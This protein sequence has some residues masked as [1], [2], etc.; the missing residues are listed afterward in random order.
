MPSLRTALYELHKEL[1]ARFT[2]FAGYE[3]PVQYKEGLR[4]EHLHT[5][6]QAGLFDVS[7]MGQVRVTGP[8]LHAAL[9]RALPIDFDDWPDGQQRYS[10]LLNDRG[11]I[12]DDL[13]VTR[14]K[15]EVRIVVNAATKGK[16]LLLLRKLCPDLTFELLDAALIALQGP[17]AESAFPE[18]AALSFMRAGTFGKY[19]VSR[20]GYT[21]ED[22]FEISVPSR[23]ADVLARRLLA[24]PAV[25]P[26]GLGARDTL[27]LEAGLH[28][29]GQDMDEKTTVL[30]ASLG[31]AIAA[32]RRLGGK[33]EGGFPGAGTYLREVKDWVARR[34][35]GLTGEEAVPIRHGAPLVDANGAEVGVVTS[36]TISPSTQKAIMLGYVK[37]G[38]G[39]D[40]PLS[41]VVR[42]ARRPVRITKLPFVPKR[43]KK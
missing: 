38:I 1:G 33:K 17:D 20:S 6:A 36:G 9:E 12:E 7:H 27:R 4:A 31:W 30:E 23:Y 40:A 22:G 34:L 14:L 19:F 8:R 35:V 24:H 16:D 32:S 42:D 10:M 5:R 41:A 25:K 28:L 21:G 2:E 43:Y 11:G 15:D 3:M 13:M 37:S 26:V 39:A 18:A 29:Y